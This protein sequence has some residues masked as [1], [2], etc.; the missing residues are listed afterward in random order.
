MRE[1]YEQLELDT[2]KQLD[3]AIAKLAE[4]SVREA[5]DMI[6]AC[7]EAPSAVRNRHEAYGIAAERL[8]KIKKAVKAI[9]GDT[10]ILLG[11]LPDPN[12]PAIEAV[13]SICNSTLEAAAVMVE[14]AAEMRRTL[15]DLYEAENSAR[16]EEPTPMEQWADAAQFQ[17]AD[18][19]D[20][21]ETEETEDE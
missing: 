7:G 18:P 20:P 10:T 14:A 12:F 13:S 17:D 15:R 11:T 6:L 2:R 21:A 19:A 8:A 5:G 4:D 9:D 3:K 1:E 16:N